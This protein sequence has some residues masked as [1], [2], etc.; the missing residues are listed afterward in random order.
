MMIALFLVRRLRYLSG[1]V[2][3]Q[4]LSILRMNRFRIEAVDAV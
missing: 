1:D 2:M 4:Y 3:D